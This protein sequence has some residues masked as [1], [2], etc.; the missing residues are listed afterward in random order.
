MATSSTLYDCN[1][2][3]NI[4]VASS[5][6]RLV[7]LCSVCLIDLCKVTHAAILTNRNVRNDVV[8]YCFYI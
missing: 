8:F 7:G 2:M 5:H 3:I 6:F 4:N 1:L